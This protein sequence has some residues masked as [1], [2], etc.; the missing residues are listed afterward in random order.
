MVVRVLAGDSIREWVG[1]I[2]AGWGLLGLVGVIRVGR[3]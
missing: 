1:V 2:R 3:G